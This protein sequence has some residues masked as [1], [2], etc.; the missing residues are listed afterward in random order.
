[1]DFMLQVISWVATIV[2]IGGTLLNI[3]KNR[4]CFVLWGTS[5]IVFIG[6]NVYSGQ[7]A[8]VALFTFNL[9]TA[10]I[11]YRAWGK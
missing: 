6:I 4:V 5:N 7:W 3:R 10:I 9:A 1:M 2:A 8:Y 11:G